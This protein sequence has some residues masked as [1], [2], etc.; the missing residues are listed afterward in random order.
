LNDRLR[1]K[2]REEIGGSY[3]PRADNLASDTFP[4]WGYILASIDVDPAKAGQISDVVIKLADD[5]AKNG[6]TEDEL[7][8][9]RLPLLTSF[10]ESL[11]TNGYW[12]SVLASAQE[13]PEKLDWAR[14]RIAD[15]EAITTS[16]LNALAKKYLPRERASRVTILPAGKPK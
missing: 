8:R 16:E 14:D 5:L 1:V 13:K 6:V 12:L 7:T 15:N 9:A 4:G 3:S 11:R 2:V 10:R